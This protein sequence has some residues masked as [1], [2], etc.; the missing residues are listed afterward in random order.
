MADRSAARPLASVSLDLD[1][2]W[3]YLKIHGDEK[4]QERPSYLGVFVPHV[5]SILAELDL[6]ITFFIVGID[7]TV[8]SDASILR[9]IADAGHEI[10]NHSF[11][12][13]SWIQQY[14]RADLEKEISQSQVAIRSATGVIPRG[15]RGPGFSWSPTLLEILAAHDFVYDAST[16]PMY[17]GP[18]ARTYYFSTAKLSSEQRRQRGHLFGRFRDGLRPSGGYR[19]LL[20]DNLTLLEI[21]VTTMPY[22]KLPFHLSYLLYLSRVSPLLMD[23]YLNTAILLCRK[24]G[25]QPSFLLHPLDLI[26][27]DQ[28]PELSFFPGMDVSSGRKL[29]LFRRALRT[30]GRSFDLVPMGE[31]ARELLDRDDLM[32]VEP[33]E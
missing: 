31:H 14:S 5:L 15:F 16:L 1:N 30:L 28:V 24:S 26:G 3:S 10:G 22:L 29:E 23:L 2:L 18:L 20:G 8:E 4:W 12:H 7:A 19:W 25:T 21:P 13:D 33:K 32:M 11:E 27:G 9:S 17:L 6:E